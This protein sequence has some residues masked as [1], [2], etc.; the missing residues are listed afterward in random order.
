MQIWHTDVSVPFR[1]TTNGDEVAWLDA[2][3]TRGPN[4]QKGTALFYFDGRT[5]GPVHRYFGLS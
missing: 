3:T 5:D 2:G 4:G 1:W